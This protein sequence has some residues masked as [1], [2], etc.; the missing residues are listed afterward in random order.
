MGGSVVG[1]TVWVSHRMGELM[2]YQIRTKPEYLVKQRTCYR[3]ESMSG[4]SFL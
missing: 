1:P 4:H 3:P 2:L